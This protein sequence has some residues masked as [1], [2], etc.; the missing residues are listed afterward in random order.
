MSLKN[1]IFEIFGF[2]RTGVAKKQKCVGRGSKSGTRGLLPRG[3]KQKPLDN[4]IWLE[5]YNMQQVLVNRP[6]LLFGSESQRPAASL[7]FV[8][9][10]TIFDTSQN[11][12][13]SNKT[14]K[15]V[16]FRALQNGSPFREKEQVRSLSDLQLETV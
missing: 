3:V 9:W 14:M 10:A 1:T 4:R 11:D 2:S 8:S 12:W 7:K 5:L 6:L 16:C 15:I 13:T